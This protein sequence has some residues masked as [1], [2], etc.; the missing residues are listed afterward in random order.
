L[1]FLF[2]SQALGQTGTSTDE[3]QA[4]KKL[5]ERLD[6]GIQAS[7]HMTY[8]ELAKESDPLSH[9]IGVFTV[10]GDSHLAVKAEER[11][12]AND[13]ILK[14]QLERYVRQKGLWE[15]FLGQDCTDPHFK[16]VPI[17]GIK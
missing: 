7:L 1:L 3:V 15:E 5:L 12:A 4:C 9:C 8:R 6:A 2:L 13:M 16:C 10:Q 17:K 11:R 14:S